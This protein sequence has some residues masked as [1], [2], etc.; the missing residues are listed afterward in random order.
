MFIL[1]HNISIVSFWLGPLI[2]STSRIYNSITCRECYISFMFIDVA[3]KHF[4]YKKNITKG[5]IYGEIVWSFLSTYIDLIHWPILFTYMH[6]SRMR[7]WEIRFNSIWSFVSNLLFIIFMCS[8]WLSIVI[9]NPNADK[10][11]PWR[12][13]DKYSLDILT[14]IDYWSM[15]LI[16]V[17]ICV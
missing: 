2:S 7:Y 3:M 6:W 8:Q 14:L 17:I 13:W 11:I 1:I 12:V 16:C 10:F 15:I 9:S 4:K 5:R